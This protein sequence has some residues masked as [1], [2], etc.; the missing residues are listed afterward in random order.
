MENRQP[1]GIR[2]LFAGQAG[3]RVGQAVTGRAHCTSV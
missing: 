1:S 3:G 2:I